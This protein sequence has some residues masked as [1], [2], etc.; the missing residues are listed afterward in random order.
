MSKKKGFDEKLNKFFAGKGFYIVLVLCVAVIGVSAYFLLT[1]RGTD[2]EGSLH[3]ALAPKVSDSQTVTPPV[4]SQKPV[5]ETPLPS[6]DVQGEDAN[7]NVDVWTEQEAEAAAAAQFVWPL[8]GEIALP[9][10]MAS[11]IFNDK[12]GDWRTHDGVDL[13]AALGT[14]VV[15]VSGGTVESVGMDDLNGMTVVIAHAGG[16]KSI[17]SNLA[18]VPTVYAGDNVMTGEVIGALGTTA[19]GENAE[20]PRLCLKMTLDGQ[21]VNPADYLPVR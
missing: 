12:M 21:S 16:L 6:E 15:A 20:S 1:D 17:Y 14:Q 19:P 8:E 13:T 4:V 10:S 18:S 2:V 7:S 9:Y 11:L 3:E 5:E